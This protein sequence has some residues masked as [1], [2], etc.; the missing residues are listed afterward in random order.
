MA[1]RTTFVYGGWQLAADGQHAVAERIIDGKR[2]RHRIGTPRKP[3]AQARAALIAWVDSFNRE[4]A[5]TGGRK[6]GA[7]WKLY[8]DD[9]ERDGKKMASFDNAWKILAP[10]YA[11]LATDDL[12]DDVH[13]QFALQMEAQDYAPWTIHWTLNK[14]RDGMNWAFKKRHIERP[15]VMWNIAQPEHN[16][17]VVTEEEVTKL[18]DAAVTD[19]VRLFILI[20]LCS[21]ARHRAICQLTWDRVDLDKCEMNFVVPR[22]GRSVI[23]KG[24]LKGR[25]KVPF[26]PM[27]RA[28]LSAAKLKAATGHVIEWNGQPVDNVAKGF[29]EAAKRAG[30]ADVTPH[31]LRHSA[32]TWAITAHGRDALENVSKLLGHANPNTTR[33]IYVHDDTS[34]RRG[35]VVSIEE[36]LAKGRKA[37]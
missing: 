21:G 8:R 2:Q 20:A 26:G 28:A 16:T 11:D 27:L 30:L 14:L 22:T 34:N 23:D 19:H 33:G 15:A 25:A 32:A 18:I 24:F 17:R 1:R 6:V 10:F 9:R 35:I 3:E 29:R 37:G 5:V 36:R 13:R 12:T 7:L 31:T 4:E